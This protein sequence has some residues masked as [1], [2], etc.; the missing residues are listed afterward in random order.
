MH[1]VFSSFAFRDFFPTLLSLPHPSQDVGDKR[2]YSHKNF[3][4]SIKKIET[5]SPELL[6][7]DLFLSTSKK[8]LFCFNVDEGKKE[9]GKEKNR[10]EEK[11]RKNN[12]RSWR[13][14]Q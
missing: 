12:W 2:N 14:R 5:T 11:K 3:R 13:Q 7:L 6:S 4:N 10:K 9:E 1:S 8:N